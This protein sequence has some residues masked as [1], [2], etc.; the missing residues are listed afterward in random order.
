[1][2]C[3]ECAVATGDSLAF[4]A[5][6]RLPNRT[7]QTGSM[8]LMHVCLCVDVWRT[9]CQKASIIIKH[10]E[11]KEFCCGLVFVVC[12]K[13]VSESGSFFQVFVVG[14]PIPKQRISGFT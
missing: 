10:K 6:P 14:L 12:V 8:I 7:I 5:N 3:V 4:T 2:P 13:S 11:K 9:R 1:M